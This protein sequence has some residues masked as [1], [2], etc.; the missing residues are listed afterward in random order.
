MP[1]FSRDNIYPLLF[2]PMYRQVCW[3]GNRL[4]AVL[5]RTLPDDEGYYGEAWDICDRPGAESIVSNGPLAGTSI[6]QLAAEGNTEFT[7][8]SLNG[9]QHR[10]PVLVKIIDTAA[11]TSLQVHPNNTIAAK[12]GNGAEPKT[13]MWYVMKAEKNAQ[14]MVGLTPVATRPRFNETAGTQQVEE[15]VMH[16]NAIPGDA[17][18]INA[19]SVHC[20]GAGCLLLEIQENSNTS[21]RIYDWETRDFDG[22]L[23]PLHLEQA[24]E[25][26]NYIDRFPARITGASNK[27][28]N[29]RKY[30]LVNKCPTFS[31]DE[32]R[33]VSDWPDT[34]RFSRSAHLL[35]AIDNTLEIHT[36]SFEP[37]MVPPGRTALLPACLGEYLLR[38]S[39]SIPTTAI[40]TILL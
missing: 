32:M 17:Y 15:Q 2:D 29:N 39:G 13:E 8:E 12:I 5:N 10:F 6:H 14:V 38:C 19:G 9:T 31:V 4:A 16:Y 1:M 28:L 35:T 7:G 26:V 22:S 23:R 20:A 37:V 36:P 18:F 3:G 25:C 40:R 21:Y 34:T 33:L 27:A 30:A 24:L 11:R